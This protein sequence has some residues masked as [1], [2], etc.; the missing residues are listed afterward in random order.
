[1]AGKK[2]P[3]GT[4]GMYGRIGHKQIGGKPVT[5]YYGRV[6]VKAEGRTRYFRLGT[7][8]KASERKYHAL[9]GDPGAALL[10]RESIAMK[11]RDTLTVADLHRQFTANYR[12]RGGTDYYVNV[13]KPIVAG[14]G[15]MRVADVTP[16]TID[17]HLSRRRSETTKGKPRREGDTIVMVGAGNRLVGESTLRKECIAAAKMFRWARGRGLTTVRPFD[18]YDKP[19]EPQG[20]PARALADDEEGKLLTALPPLERDLVTWALDAGMRRGEILSLTW[21]RIDRAA[22]R[23]H[24]V[25]TKTGRGRV[26]PLTLSARL[27]DVLARHPQ[28]T[29]TALLFHDRDGQ[30]LDV[31]RINGVIESA[32]RIAGIPKIRGS[33][34]N[35]LRKTWVS[36]I[37]AAGALPQ[38]EAEWGGHSMTIATR[39][40]LQFSPAANAGADGLL[41]RAKGGA[42]DGAQDSKIA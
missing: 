36:R 35:V 4:P 41:D 18:D 38:Q 28:R 8:L 34:W 22:G 23:I 19:K 27:S 24:V 26:V 17:A 15:K 7:G 29:D 32:M 5:T 20:P 13:L 25:E 40:Y 2:I 33:L 30:P 3:T 12:G 39:H 31:D 6:Y 21:P 10:E 14:I 16:A 42:R 9:L 11:A 1:M 37:Y